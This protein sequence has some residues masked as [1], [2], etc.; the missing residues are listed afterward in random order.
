MKK[1]F[2][3]ERW[4]KQEIGFHQAEINQYLK[5]FWS[6]IKTRHPDS[7][8][9]VPLCGKTS[10]MLWLNQQGHKVLGI[11]FS[12]MAVNDFFT[13]NQLSFQRKN[14]GNFEQF[15]TPDLNL[16]CGDF[17][18]LNADMLKHCHLVYDRA[19]LVALPQPLRQDY[20]N[21]MHEILPDDTVMLLISMEYSQD[22]M[23]GPPFSVSEEEIYKLYNRQFTIEKLGEYDIFAE[24]PRFKAKGLTGLIEKVFYLER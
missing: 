3:L 10:D 22:E 5:R 21:K 13:E 24:N 16:M 18:Q 23:N 1:N 11:E 12:E 4:Q 19:S 9:F 20:A 8:V 15:K 2:W 17:F 14:L 6:E 7:Q